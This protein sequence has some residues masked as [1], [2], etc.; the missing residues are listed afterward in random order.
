MK[1]ILNTIPVLFLLL[2]VAAPLPAGGVDSQ[3]G[4]PAAEIDLSLPSLSDAERLE[5]ILARFDRAQVAIRTL[6]AEFSERKELA[7]LKDPVSSEGHFFYARP[8]QAKWAHRAPDERIIVISDN[9]LMQYYPDR[10]ILERKKLSHANTNRLFKLFGM[11]QSSRELKKLYDISLGEAQ[12]GENV[13]MLVLSPKRKA[14]RKRLSRVLLWVG[15][16]DFLPH[17]MKLEEANGDFTYWTFQNLQIN[18][19]L[20]ANTFRLDVPDDV[21][22]RDEFEIFSSSRGNAQ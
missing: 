15:D 10:K 12:E 11:G 17:A 19:E 3:E 2:A 6:T 18:G 21:E 7:L 8:H 1:P 5:T 20:A 16:Q 4:H 14:L 9:T 13:Y 22:V